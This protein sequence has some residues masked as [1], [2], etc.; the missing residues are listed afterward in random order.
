MMVSGGDKVVSVRMDGE[1]YRE[2]EDMAKESGRSVSSA[3]GMVMKENN[4]RIKSVKRIQNIIKNTG[5]EDLTKLALKTTRGFYIW[6]TRK[7]LDEIHNLSKAQQQ[8][9]ADF[10]VD[11]VNNNLLTD[12]CTVLY[13]NEAERE[14]VITLNIG[15]I[16]LYCAKHPFQMIIYDV[17]F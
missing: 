16:K 5:H 7:S 6:I 8:Q 11:C 15:K 10:I 1:L 13:H 3:I 4:Q 14:K 17:E 9:I 12:K 2:T